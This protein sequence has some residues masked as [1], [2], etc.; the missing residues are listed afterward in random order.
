VFAA[1]EIREARNRQGVKY[2]TG[3]WLLVTQRHPDSARL[4]AIGKSAVCMAGM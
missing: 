4:A 1:L 3:D 2:S